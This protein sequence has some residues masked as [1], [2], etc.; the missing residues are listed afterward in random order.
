MSDTSFGGRFIILRG[1]GRKELIKM[2][3]YFMLNKAKSPLKIL[4]RHIV[5]GTD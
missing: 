5:G 1:I 3:R 4:E 2:R